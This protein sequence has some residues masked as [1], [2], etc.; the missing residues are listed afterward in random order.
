MNKKYTEQDI[1]RLIWEFESAVTAVTRAKT[2]C[3][4]WQA[5][6]KEERDRIQA[7][8]KRLLADVRVTRQAVLDA[9]KETSS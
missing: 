2:Y 9:M 6:T 8:A 3:E 1:Y 5:K 4:C 7:T